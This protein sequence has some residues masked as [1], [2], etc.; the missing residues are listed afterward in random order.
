MQIL[1]WNIAGIRASLKR[2]DFNF[3]KNNSY[4]IIC[5]QETKATE[6]EAEKHLPTWLK[7]MYPYR[8]WR[9]TQGIT[10]RK[11]FSGTCIW[12]NIEPIQN[13]DPPDIDGEGRVTAVEYDNCILVNVYTPNSQKVDSERCLFRLGLWDSAFREYIYNLNNRKPTIVCGDFNVANEDIDIWGGT[14]KHDGK[15]CVG[16][17]D[18]ERLNFKNHL[19]IG[20]IDA[21]RYLNSEGNNYTYWDQRMPWLRKQ[22]KGWRIDYYLVP[23][24]LGDRITSCLIKKDIMGSDHCPITLHIDVP[25]STVKSTVKSRAKLKILKEYT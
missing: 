17:L 7:D 9:S 20:Y 21:F 18:E 4:D 25:E 13:V 10:Q 24:S 3:L 14:A 16:F 22:N 5:I 11:G 8:Y 12:S 1:C 19:K 2:G 15:T 6:E 23:E